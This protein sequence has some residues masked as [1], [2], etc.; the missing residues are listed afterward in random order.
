MQGGSFQKPIKIAGLISHKIIHSMHSQVMDLKLVNEET[1]T[2]LIVISDGCTN[3]RYN[4]LVKRHS[5]L[6][7]PVASMEIPN[8][9]L[10]LW[11]EKLAMQCQQC[12]SV[13]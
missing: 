3:R 8:S 11:T 13:F 5:R 6:T 4:A 1:A 9:L 7:Q 2:L 10:I 12:N